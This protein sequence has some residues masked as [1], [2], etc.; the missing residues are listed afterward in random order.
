MKEAWIEE[1]RV[2]ARFHRWQAASMVKQMLHTSNA[3]H[4][5]DWE[6]VNPRKHEVRRKRRNIE[7][8]A[9]IKRVRDESLA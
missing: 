8:Y 1:K 5:G 4:P 6:T 2:V 9:P 7:G 3:L